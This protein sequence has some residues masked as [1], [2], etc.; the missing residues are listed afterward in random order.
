MASSSLEL[1]PDRGVTFP[2]LWLFLWAYLQ[3]Q[4]GLG[5]EKAKGRSQERAQSKRVLQQL[6]HKKRHVNYRQIRVTCSL[7][8][9]SESRV[10]TW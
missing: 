3:S 9:L 8:E 7:S 5:R 10:T 6:A 2:S 1:S 4:S